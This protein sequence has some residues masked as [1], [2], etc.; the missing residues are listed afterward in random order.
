MDDA[1][2][3]T[4]DSVFEEAFAASGMPG[5]AASVRIGSE[6]WT[7]AVGVGDLATQEPFDPQA[8]IR[9]ASNTKTFT[10]TAVLQLVDAGAWRSMIRWRSMCRA[11][12]TGSGSRCAT[13][14]R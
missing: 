13:C 9:I 5:A 12:R 1:T 6:V 4:L 10:A 3:E 8:F 2:R 14:C 7:S 11:S